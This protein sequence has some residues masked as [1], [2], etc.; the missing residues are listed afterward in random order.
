MALVTTQPAMQL[1]TGSFPGVKRL[2]RIDHPLPSSAEV[3]QRIELYLYCPLGLHGLLQGDLLWHPRLRVRSRP[4]PSDF[5]GNKI[6]RMPPFGGEVKP[7]VPCRRFAACKKTPAIYVEVGI[8]G[9]I[10]WSFL[11]QFRPSLTEVSHSLDM[12][13]LW[14][15]RAELKAVH[16][17]TAA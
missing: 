1:S 14:R 2:G 9:K 12:E 17:G 11:A 5:S 10:G 15:W 13:R 3:K 8:A 6:H 7:S 16:K 4:K